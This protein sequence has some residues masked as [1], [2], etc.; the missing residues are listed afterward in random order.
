MIE[1][2]CGKYREI[3]FMHSGSSEGK[4]DRERED[5][6]YFRWINGRVEKEMEHKGD[7]REECW[8]R[9]MGRTGNLRSL[10]AFAFK[11]GD[12]LSPNKQQ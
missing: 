3:G 4:R 6:G 8:N 5:N 9:G 7:R 11:L 10:A 1:F 2:V 12:I